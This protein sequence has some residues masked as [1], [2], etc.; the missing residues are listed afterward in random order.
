[1][2]D[3]VNARHERV[4]T[5]LSL[6]TLAIPG[7]LQRHQN[8]LTLHPRRTFRKETEFEIRNRKM[9][10]DRLFHPLPSHLHCGFPMRLNLVSCRDTRW[11]V[12]V[13]TPAVTGPPAVF[14]PYSHPTSRKG[15]EAD[16]LAF[17]TICVDP[18]WFHREDTKGY[19]RFVTILLGK[20][21]S[22]DRL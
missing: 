3:D 1:M 14:I 6:H 13:W 21:V 12:L 7:A 10:V 18:G 22:L 20:N 2:A 8:C 11:F 4:V 5:R 17:S 16:S 15:L 9:H 19:H